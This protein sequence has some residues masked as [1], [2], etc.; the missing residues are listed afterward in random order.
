MRTELL[1]NRKVALLKYVKTAISW[2][3]HP[4][5]FAKNAR[6]KPRAVIVNGVEEI[7]PEGNYVL[8]YYE[9]GHSV[10]Q[11]A[12]NDPT[13]AQAAR[14]RQARLMAAKAA[15]DDAGVKLEGVSPDRLLLSQA[16]LSEVPL[17]VSQSKYSSRILGQE[18][19]RNTCLGSSTCSSRRKNALALAWVCGS[20]RKSWNRPAGAFES[21]PQPV[22]SGMERNSP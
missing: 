4:A 18:P 15:A 3:R 1:A 10:F 13:D 12:G 5:V 9:G 2:R 19:H 8:R 7:H 14:E 22:K 6:I 11:P 21:K 20:R 17:T 16:D